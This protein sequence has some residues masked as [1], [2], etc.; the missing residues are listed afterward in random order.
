MFQLQSEVGQLIWLLPASMLVG[1]LFCFLWMRSLMQTQK[2]LLRSAMDTKEKVLSQN[3]EGLQNQLSWYEKKTNNLEE[4]FESIA[5]KTTQESNESF[6][7]LAQA[8]FR[9]SD[10]QR[11]ARDESIQKNQ[12]ENM[13]RV[14]SD[15]KEAMTQVEGQIR[16]LEQKRS[17]A[18][19][20]IKEQISQVQKTHQSLA[21]ETQALGKALGSPRSRGV[22]GELQLR[23]VVESAGMLKHSDFL[24]QK[25]FTNKD[26]KQIRPD[27]VVRLPGEKV[28]PVDAKVPLNAY[29][30]ASHAKSEELAAQHWKAH[31]DSLKKHILRLSQKSYWSG[32]SDSTDF[33]VLFLPGECFL[34]PAFEED[35]TLITYA[36]D[37]KVVLATPTNLIAILRTVASAWKDHAVSNN[38]KKIKDLGASLQ[39]RLQKFMSLLREHGNYI[40][41]SIVSYNQL[42]GS[43]QSRLAP[44]LRQL[45]EFGFEGNGSEEQK[46]LTPKKFEN[47]ET[48]SLRPRKDGMQ[49]PEGGRIGS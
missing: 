30:S 33:V 40:E 3:M 32:F 25:T 21:S 23:R 42:V 46:Q 26:D 45:Q 12:S 2:E 10:E 4:S 39:S 35:P 19:A 5:R 38:A 47:P 11:T 7:R 27:L 44:S 29:L 17:G 34:Q 28:I 48:V 24:E 8:F 43:A 9:S 36:L 13:K 1:G 31:A 16:E 15:I 18:Y 22:W 20:S 14:Y 6:M 49:S 37:H 41:K